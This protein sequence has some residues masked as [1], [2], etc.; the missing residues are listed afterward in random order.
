MNL[1]PPSGPVPQS[2]DLQDAASLRLV[3]VS[4]SRGAAATSS[5]VAAQLPEISDPAP[6]KGLSGRVAGHFRV[7]PAR[8]FEI[9]T[10]FPLLFRSSRFNETKHSKATASLHLHW[11]EHHCFCASLP[12]SVLTPCSLFFQFHLSPSETLPVAPI[13]A[14]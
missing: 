4:A 14:Q 1:P 9:Y 6:R 2:L 5:A 10:S 12:P 7:V 8:T 13:R 11:G 3:A